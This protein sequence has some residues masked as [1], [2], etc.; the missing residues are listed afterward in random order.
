ME[1]TPDLPALRSRITSTDRALVRLLGERMQLVSEVAACKRALGAPSFDR[2]RESEVLDAALAEATAAGL[3]PDLVR[4]VMGHVLAAS[5]AA[6]R[7]SLP[8]AEDAPRSIGVI[9][10]TAG[11]GA[12]LADVF[13]RGGTPV[14][15]TGLERGAPAE[16]VAGRHDL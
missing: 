15:T 8:P 9:G 16:E 2:A 14:E 5:R 11:M 10:G 6:Q 4:G 13:A 12:F 7:T 1:P 3:P